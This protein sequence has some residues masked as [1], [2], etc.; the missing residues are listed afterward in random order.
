MTEEPVATGKI[1]FTK[2]KETLLMTLYGRAL[3][4]Q[5]EHPILRDPWA[6]EA[7]RRIDYDF[8]KLYG[9]AGVFGHLVSGLGC[10]II[11]TRAGTFDLETTRYLADH[12]EATVLHLGCGLDARVFRVDPPVSVSWFDV[13]YPDVIAV[14]RQLLPERPDYHL[15]GA[16]LEDLR[17]LDEVAGDRP[18]L[19]VAEG[20]L[21]YLSEAN[22]KALLNAVT[23]HFASGQLVFDAV[24]PWIARRTGS[25]VGGTG[26]SYRW[27]LDEPQDIKR[28]DPKLEL[29]K[30]YTRPELVA[31]R[32]FP[33]AVRALFLLLDNVPAL[34]RMERPLVYRF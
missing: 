23:G 8:S 19:V 3:Q 33:L 20:V 17:W 14:R 4:S 30:E 27:G 5:W 34:R 9:Y 31:Y 18:V 11:A 12:P 15:I 22:V 13:D 1:E 29:V 2:E 7:V 28:L 25:N 6:E 26:A 16:P 32:R 21:M 10:T 24:H